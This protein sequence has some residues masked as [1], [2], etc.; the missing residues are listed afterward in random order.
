MAAARSG[1]PHIHGAWPQ[2]QC[3]PSRKISH[4]I[5]GGYYRLDTLGII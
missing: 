4:H 1:W 3:L 2:N 5:I